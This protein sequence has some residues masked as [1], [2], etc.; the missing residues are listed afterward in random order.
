MGV[1]PNKCIWLGLGR[2]IIYVAIGIIGVLA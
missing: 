2:D 1:A